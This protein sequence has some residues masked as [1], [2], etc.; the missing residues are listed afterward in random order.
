MFSCT[1]SWEKCTGFVSRATL[2]RHR[3]A[4]MMKADQL[5]QEEAFERTL[6]VPDVPPRRPSSVP[7]IPLPE[8]EVKDYCEAPHLPSTE[9]EEND[10][11]SFAGLMPQWYDSVYQSMDDPNDQLPDILLAE[12]IALYSEWM[13]AFKVTDACAKAVYVMLNTLLPED[14][15]IG[16]WPQLKRALEQ[17]TTD[18][19]VEIDVCPNDCIAYINCTHPKLAH[20]K[21]AHRTWCPQCGTDRFLIVDRVQRPAKRAFYFPLRNYLQGLF[22]SDE[23]AEYLPFD[24][25][26]RPSGHVKNSWGWH[27]KVIQNPFMN[28]EKRNQTLVGMSDGIPMFRSKSS[29]GVVTVALRNANLPDELSHKFRHIHLAGLYPCRYVFELLTYC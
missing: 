10:R 22:G 2:Y 27:H 25:G 19:V 17:V 16:S 28:A 6:V 18:S 15:N 21:H 8:P 3:L 14:A 12:L 7:N 13:F 20:Y 1:C 24:E 11:H 9:E 23:L 4:S 26:E 5:A 29:R